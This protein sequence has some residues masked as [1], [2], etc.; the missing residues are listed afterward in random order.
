MEMSAA[1]FTFLRRLGLLTIAL[2]LPPAAA[3]AQ[4]YPERVVRVVVPVSAGGLADTLARAVAQRFTQTWG[5]QFI[6]ENKPGGDFQIGLNQVAKSPPDGYTLLVSPDA[7]FVI[8][9]ALHSKLLYDPIADFE[10]ITGLASVDQALVVHPSLKVKTV[11]E[12]IALAKAKPG[13]LNFGSF[14]VGSTSYLHMEMFQS[15]TGL[16]LVPV[17]YKGAAPMITDVV[18]GHVP[19]MIVSIG[20]VL[21]LVKTGKLRMLAVGS[22][23]RLSILPGVPT[24]EESGLPGF[25]ARAWFGLFAPKRT[26]N[27]IVVKLNTEMQ[28]ALADPSLHTNVLASCVCEAMTDSPEGFAAFMKAEDTKWR[29]LARA[30]N[31]RID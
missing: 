11:Q 5:Q 25:R 20:Q 26:P 9:P 4:T 28:R 16:K 21:P 18:G 15:M 24:M 6:V 8:S 14:G 19:M 29:G 22:A 13:E 7:P 30:A 1:L 10:P 23:K 27:E 31:I 17:H 12:L 3:L 2:V